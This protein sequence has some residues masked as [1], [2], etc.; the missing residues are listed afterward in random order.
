MSHSDDDF[1]VMRDDEVM[2]AAADVLAPLTPDRAPT[3]NAEL[4]AM[5]A[6]RITPARS[7][8][9]RVSAGVTRFAGLGAAAKLMLAAGVAVAGAG[10]AATVAYET[11]HLDNHHSHHSS[12][13]P[14]PGDD[15]GHDAHQ[16]P[17]GT[18]RTSPQPVQSTEPESGDDHPGQ[19]RR[20]S[21]SNGSSGGNGNGSDDNSGRGS[22]DR[23]GDHHGGRRG[24]DGTDDNGA[25]GDQGG[26]GNG[27]GDQGGPGNG[28]GGGD[29]GGGVDN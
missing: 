28:G 27:A 19:H 9:S 10:G 12:N 3:A 13:H 11:G 15:N 29:Q 6:S 25:Q 18:T 23:H 16:H 7:V 22:G 20:S 2:R 26:P 17:S 1:G 8:R 24:P 21:G 4:M 14:E 5:I